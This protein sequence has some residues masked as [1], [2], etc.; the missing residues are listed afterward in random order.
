MTVEAC[1]GGGGRIDHA[2]LA[3]T[4]VVWPSDETGPRDR[5]AIQHGFLGVLPAWT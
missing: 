3:R 2:V 1:A 4:D 5:L